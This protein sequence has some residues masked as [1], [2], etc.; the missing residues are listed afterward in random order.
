VPGGDLA[1][2]DAMGDAVCD[3]PGL[4]RAGAG[5]NADWPGRSRDGRALLRV[6]P[7][8]HPAGR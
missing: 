2:Q 3:R 5:E 8:Q 4:P 7:G 6:E 1:G